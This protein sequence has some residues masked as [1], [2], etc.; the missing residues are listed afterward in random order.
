MPLFIVMGKLTEKALQKMRDARERDAR[1]GEIIRN[2][3]GKLLSHYY[4]F[5]RYDFIVIVEMPSAEILA[6]VII[7]IAEAGAVS[8][9]TMTAI[10]PEQMYGMAMRM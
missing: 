10:L 1:A 6:K 8:T 2:A 9:E 5:G 7:D 3:G 4:T